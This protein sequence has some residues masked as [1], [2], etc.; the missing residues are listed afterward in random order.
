M[1]IVKL[2][3]NETYKYALILILSVLF[4]IY[5][6]ISHTPLRLI[7]IKSQKKR[8]KIIKYQLSLHYYE[9]KYNGSK[10]SDIKVK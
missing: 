3:K 4:N 5:Q 6:C 7:I 2:Y 10:R 1:R 9:Y 8:N